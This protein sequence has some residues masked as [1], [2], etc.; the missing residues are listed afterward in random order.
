MKLRDIIVGTAVVTVGI[1]TGTALVLKKYIGNEETRQNVK[2]KAKDFEKSASEL[3]KSFIDI[4]KT[5]ASNVVSEDSSIK[6]EI[7]EKVKEAQ[8]TP[9]DTPQS[10]PEDTPEDTEK[11]PKETENVAFGFDD[12]VY[13]NT[14]NTEEKETE[15][16]EEI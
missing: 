4:T 2:T 13:S 1:A 14:E 5:T 12:S 16:N 3:G 10:T 6:E 7:K 9:E 15:H 11:E 8:D